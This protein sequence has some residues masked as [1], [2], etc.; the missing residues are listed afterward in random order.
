MPAP[1]SAAFGIIMS[2]TMRPSSLHD[3]PRLPR[4]AAYSVFVVWLMAWPGFGVVFAA[5]EGF[6]TLWQI[7]PLAGTVYGLISAVVFMWLFIRRS[8]DALPTLWQGGLLGVVTG[9]VSAPLLMLGNAA[10]EVH[11][12][13]IAC[14]GLLGVLLTHQSIS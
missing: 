12:V 5:L 6:P 2:M 10:M 4:A 3:R 9:L 1:V 7:Y 8:R 14:A 13:A 11:T